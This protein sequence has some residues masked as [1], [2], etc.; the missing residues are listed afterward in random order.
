VAAEK[1]A[2]LLQIDRFGDVEEEF[3][4]RK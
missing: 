3:S 4:I 2:Q 1:N